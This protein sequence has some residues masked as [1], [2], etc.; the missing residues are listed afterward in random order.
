MKKH[1]SSK[2][3]TGAAAALVLLAGVGFAP[4]A[5][6]VAVSELPRRTHIHGLAVD[7]QDPSKLLVAT[8]HG[9][10]RAG[11]DGKAERISE[12]QDLVGFNPHPSDPN[13]LYASGHPGA[14]EL[15]AGALAGMG[16]SR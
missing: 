5:E 15:R 1:V 11:P 4:A 6:T 16:R 12:V 7:R 13:T 14:G 3:T 9:L 2:G 8:H 10:F